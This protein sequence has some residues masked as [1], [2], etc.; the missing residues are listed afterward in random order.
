MTA[1]A[2]L[3]TA[4]QPHL[5]D[6][7]L[8]RSLSN[9]GWSGSEKL[10]RL[11]IGLVVGLWVARYLQSHAYGQLQF[12]V[13]WVALFN[14]IA[15]L[16]V[17]ETVLRDL[18]QRPADEGRILGAALLLRVA[19][20]CLA[21][22]LAVAGALW[23][24]AADP[25]VLAMVLVLSLAIPFAE[26]P[27]GVF[28]WLQAHGRLRGA[29]LAVNATRLAAALAKVALIVL[30]FG[31]LAFAWV[32]LAEAVLTCAAIFAIWS[33]MAGHRPRWSAD[34]AG[35]WQMLASG[36]P[37]ALAALAT[38]L[39]SRVDQLMLGWLAGFG[40]VGLYA[41][42]TRFSEIWW[43]LPP[44]L[45]NSIAP[46]YIYGHD[47]DAAIRRRV[48]WISASLAVPAVAA[49]VLT[50]L[51]GDALVALA[52]GPG[53]AGAGAILAVHIWL[54]VFLF[55]DAP[56]SHYLVATHRQRYLTGKTLLTLA[57]NLALNAWL[58]PRHGALGA[59]IAT[60]AATA[61]VNTGFYALWR[62]TRDIVRLQLAV[63]RLLAF[64]AWRIG[65]RQL[66]RLFA[67]PP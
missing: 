53:Y 4:L 19:G 7:R 63:A 27:A 47:G 30:G 26:A 18:V 51:W 60:L 21:A 13:S 39:N 35:A 59:A 61:A 24:H 16:G 6:A 28:L 52:L 3:R 55:L 48:A 57:A 9:I 23:F 58:V 44:M 12:A 29:V 14:A 67:V 65:F 43:I 45:L 41:A 25:L 33:A 17:G 56:L 11:V 34:A 22:G 46:A 49:S 8:R 64:D 20:S 38:S 42:A 40:Q 1:L 37:L 31:V 62:G 32:G 5:R 15:W 10:L 50:T 36:A 54:T 2:R 66:Q